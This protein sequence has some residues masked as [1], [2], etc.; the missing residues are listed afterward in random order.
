M[1]DSIATYL[2]E[3]TPAY[4]SMQQNIFILRQSKVPESNLVQLLKINM[5][6]KIFLKQAAF[7]FYFPDFRMQVEILYCGKTVT[8]VTTTGPEG[9]FIMQGRVLIANERIYGP[10]STQQISFPTPASVALPQPLTDAMNRLLC[11]LE[12]GVLL[13]VAP[14]GMFIKRFCRGRVYWNGPMAQSTDH[15]NKLERE[16]TFKLLDIPTFLSGKAVHAPSTTCI[17]TL[18]E[19][20]Y[21]HKDAIFKLYILIKLHGLFILLL[22][23]LGLWVLCNN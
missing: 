6:L 18:V 2:I 21:G 1:L 3:S 7:V 14:D 10:C 8:K 4:T 23:F 17:K 5:L 9:C 15:P 22:L 12:K 16:K 19:P 11:H 20:M 13:W